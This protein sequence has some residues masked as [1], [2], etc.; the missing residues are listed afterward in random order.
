MLE[1]LERLISWARMK[2]KPEKSRSLVLK[3]GKEKP[4]KSLG[5]WFDTSL[6]DTE[7]ITQMVIQ[8]EEWMCKFDRSGLPGKYKAWCYQHGVL[9][10]LLWPL[11]IYDVPLPIVDK[12]ERKISGH[13]R[14]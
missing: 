10:R 2:F 1:D 4:V 14:R 11:M 3:K 9:P 13:L 7:S 8:G 12:M 5:K 6:K